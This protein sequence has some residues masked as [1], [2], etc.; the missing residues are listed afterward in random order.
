VK[1]TNYCGSL[2]GITGNDP[3][4]PST[5]ALGQNYPNPFNPATVIKY[6]LPNSSNVIIKVFDILGKEVSTLVNERIEA[7]YH[8]VEFNGGNLASGLYLYKI[9]ADGFTEVKKMMLIK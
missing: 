9:E 5:F 7:G 6:Q 2:V 1:F 3:L 8:Q 4:L